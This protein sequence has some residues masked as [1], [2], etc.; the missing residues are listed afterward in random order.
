MS[1]ALADFAGLA[2]PWR[3]AAPGAR[4]GRG[5]RRPVA[6][7]RAGPESTAPRRRRPGHAPSGC[8]ADGPRRRL[9]A[10][11]ARRPRR[12][13]G[14]CRA[15][16]AARAGRRGGA[17]DGRRARRAGRTDVVAWVGPHVC[18]GCYEVPEAMRAEVTDVVPAAV[19]TTSWGAA[20]GRRRRR[21]ACPAR[22]PAGVDRRRRVRVHPW[23]PRTCTPTAATGARSGRLAGLVRIRPRRGRRAH[24]ADRGRSATRHAAGSPAP[25]RGRGPRPR[26]GDA[27]RRDQVLP[28]LRRP[29]ARRPRRPRTWGRTAT[30]RPCAKAA[31]CADRSDL[32][33]HFVG[34]LQSNKAARGRAATPSWVE[35]VDR[36]SSSVPSTAA[37]TSAPRSRLPGPGQPRPAGRGRRPGRRRPAPTSPRWP[38][39]SP[40]RGAP[41]ARRDGRGTARR[42]PGAGVR[43]ARRAY[44]ATSAPTHPDADLALGRDERGPGGRDRMRCDTR[45]DRPRG[46]R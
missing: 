44:A 41:A 3:D 31:E 28:R 17:G 8:R 11:P 46:A 14:R 45:T 19:A 38:P 16:R 40:R 9:R 23:S 18:G 1:P 35:S 39:I 5:R 30:R 27:R 12:R 20:G 4:L 26:R 42:G 25:A 22:A 36:P 21:G 10:G 24:G 7:A 2:D 15:R 13:C 43:P 37:R 6:T 33:W 29:G 34:G 32:R